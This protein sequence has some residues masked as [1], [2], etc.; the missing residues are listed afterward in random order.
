MP[1]NGAHL[2]QGQGPLG[3]VRPGRM[4]NWGDGQDNVILRVEE[5]E[6]E[7]N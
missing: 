5:E 4:T 3:P 7:G 6:E 1:M 2:S